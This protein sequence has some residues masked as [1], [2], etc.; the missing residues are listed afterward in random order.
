[1]PNSTKQQVE[2]KLHEVMGEAKQKAGE[3][4]GDEKLE[5]EG[6]AEKVSGTVQKG[7]GKLEEMLGK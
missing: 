6:L 5:A 7:L 3:I 2:G 4:T 1:M